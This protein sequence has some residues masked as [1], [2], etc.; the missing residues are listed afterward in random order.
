MIDAIFS[1]KTNTPGYVLTIGIGPSTSSSINCMYDE[2]LEYVDYLN[3]SPSEQNLFSILKLIDEVILDYKILNLIINVRD[4][5]NERFFKSLTNLISNPT[6]IIFLLVVYPEDENPDS[7]IKLQKEKIIR[8]GNQ[9]NLIVPFHEDFRKL[10]NGKNHDAE[11][12]CNSDFHIMWF[13]KTINY[14]AFAPTIISSDFNDIYQAVKE[15]GF[16]FF[17]LGEFKGYYPEHNRFQEALNNLIKNEHN[18]LTCIKEAKNILIFIDYGTYELHE[19]E[20]LYPINLLTKEL[21]PDA[22]ILWNCGFYELQDRVR[23]T[24]IGTGLNVLS[25]LK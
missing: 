15:N 5:V 19:D 23:I 1:S 4:D 12:Y 6:L 25:V 24:I 7:D 14:F 18:A 21:N 22:E 16:G 2:G 20:I 9:V 3:I 8:I 11:P 17:A 10:Y 13:V